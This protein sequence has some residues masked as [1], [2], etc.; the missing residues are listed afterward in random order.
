[1]EIKI[2]GSAAG[3]GIPALFC[4][5]AVCESA[6]KNGGKEIRTRSG[7]WVNREILIDFSRDINWQCIRH[8]IRAWEAEG[9][10]FTHSHI[11]HLHSEELC[12]RYQWYSDLP[13]SK[14]VELYCNQACEEEIRR[15]VRFDTGKEADFLRFHRLEPFSPV[16][17]GTLTITPLPAN[18]MKEEQALVFLL[19]EGASSCFY[20]TDSAL[21]PEQTIRYLERTHLGGV[22]MDCTYGPALFCGN[23][24]MGLGANEKLRQEL[25]ERGIAD[26][27][28]RWMLT[29]F[30]HHCGATHRQLCDAAEPAGFEVA[31][32][33]FTMTI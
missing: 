26:E 17:L 19:E 10:F 29:H 2:L 25:L 16:S 14:P 13:D 31:Y 18:H 7:A 22:Y 5:C 1:M 28:T 6:R 9:I 20:C 24:H 30:S 32:D 15:A 11:D 33:G 21:P 27:H 12:L 4:D 23:T 3:D 8:G